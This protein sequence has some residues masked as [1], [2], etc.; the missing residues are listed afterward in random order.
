MFGEDDQIVSIPVEVAQVR[1]EIVAS[2]EIEGAHGR[3]FGQT[4]GLD[5]E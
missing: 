3:I 4:G 2:G 1:F 5:D